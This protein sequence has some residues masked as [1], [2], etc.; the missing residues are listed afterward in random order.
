MMH[1]KKLLSVLI[2]IC[3]LAGGVIII[4]VDVE[5]KIDGRTTEAKVQSRLRALE[6]TQMDIQ[7]IL[8]EHEEKIKVLSIRR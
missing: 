8:V 7:E 5:E 1:E 3:R 2:I 6:K 4:K